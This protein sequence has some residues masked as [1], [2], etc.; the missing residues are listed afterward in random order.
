MKCENCGTEFEK[1]AENQKFCCRD[2]KDEKNYTPVELKD[3]ICTVCGKVYKGNGRMKYCSKECK[4]KKKNIYNKTY[5]A[6]DPDVWKCM[7]CK[8]KFVTRTSNPF[9][10]LNCRK[11]YFIKKEKANEQL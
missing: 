10:S 1:R 7:H 4:N 11:N 5:F 3:M 2:C 9:C 6:K 8:R